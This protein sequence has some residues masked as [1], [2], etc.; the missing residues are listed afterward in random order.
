MSVLAVVSQMIVLAFG[1]VL[2]F[3]ARKIGIMTDAFDGSLTRL[4]RDPAMHDSLF[5]P[6]RYCRP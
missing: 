4:V 2:G 3:V 5:H 6:L 1:V